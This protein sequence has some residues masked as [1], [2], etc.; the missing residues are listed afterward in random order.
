MN[1][2]KSRAFFRVRLVVYG[3]AIAYFGVQA[4]RAYQA[5][6]DALQRADQATQSPSQAGGAGMPAGTKKTVTLPN[7]ETIEY[8]ST[9]LPRRR[10]R[11]CR[12]LDASS[13]AMRPRPNRSPHPNR[14]PRPNRSPHP[15]PATNPPSG[16]HVAVSQ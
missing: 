12:P 13:P 14:S 3:A 2:F 15:H 11:S 1:F 5:K 9:N 7:G 8:M 16:S 6:S 10:R 4:L